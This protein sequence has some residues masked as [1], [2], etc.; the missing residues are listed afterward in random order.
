MKDYLVSVP[1]PADN[2][3]ELDLVAGS[4]GNVWFTLY[5]GDLIGRITPAGA[6]QKYALPSGSQIFYPAV[7][8][9]DGDLWFID[10]GTRYG[11]ISPQGIIAEYP[12]PA[13]SYPAGAPRF[14]ADGAMWFPLNPERYSTALTFL[15]VAADGTTTQYSTAQVHAGASCPYRAPDGSL[16]TATGNTLV[17]LDTL[18]KYQLYTIDTADTLGLMNSPDGNLWFYGPNILGE[19]MPSG[20]PV[21]RDRQPQDG[22]P[23]PWY[24]L[25]AGP[26][27]TFWFSSPEAIQL[28]TIYRLSPTGAVTQFA[29]PGND[30]VNQVILGPDQHIWFSEGHFAQVGRIEV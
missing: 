20:Q 17:S 25:I 18:G 9:A 6:V 14:C 27:G 30:S 28:G 2:E 19:I 4:D 29:N 21:V 24:D 8:G 23:Q 15:R 11:K 16:W 10:S 26:D 3:P 7:L 1:G 5:D 22:S 13:S 12:F